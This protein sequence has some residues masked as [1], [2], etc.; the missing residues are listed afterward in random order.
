MR[1]LRGQTDT[2]NENQSDFARLAGG[3]MPFVRKYS[4]IC[5]YGL[6][7]LYLDR[8]EQVNGVL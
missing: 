8:F 1:L 2:F 4:T 5:V 3:T 7:R 6:P